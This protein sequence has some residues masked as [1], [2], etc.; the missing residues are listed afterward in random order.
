MLHT[1]LLNSTYECMDFISDRKVYKHLA[2]DKVDI[3][4]YWEGHQFHFGV[5][6]VIEYPAVMRLRHH[7]R[8]IP[9]KVRFNRTGVFR[10]DQY[11][12][13]Y[14]AKALTPAKLTMDHIFPK[15]RGGENSWR[16]C[17]TACFVCNN[18]KGNRT[19]DEAGMKLIRNPFTPVLGITNE[20]HVLKDKHESWK[21]YIPVH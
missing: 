12:C 9:R 13:Q 6:N 8:W 5:G 3:L 7:V 15:A 1:L 2:N 14:C 21:N 16:N 17:V 4:E 10:R 18:K 11:V 20:Y 19:P